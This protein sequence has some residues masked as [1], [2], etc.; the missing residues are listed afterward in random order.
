MLLLL[1]LFTDV[2]RYITV[3]IP[4]VSPASTWTVAK[5]IDIG[6]RTALQR[7]RCRQRV[8]VPVCS[9]QRLFQG[10]RMR[11]F[12]S[13]SSAG[14]EIP[15]LRAASSSLV[16]L[17]ISPCSHAVYKGHY[18]CLKGTGRT[19]ESGLKLQCNLL[20]VVVV[21]IRRRRRA[22]HTASAH[23]MK[24]SYLFCAVP[25][26]RHTACSGVVNSHYSYGNGSEDHRCSQRSIL[27]V[28]SFSLFI[29]LMHRLF[30]PRF[31]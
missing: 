11:Y 25:Y 16:R 21:C 30:V 27:C 8:G 12:N 29:H 14:S 24:T 18:L 3:V 4:T 6:C 22:E 17:L 19:G 26:R 9:L 31:G 15:R 5:R 28:T 23:K 13:P 1:C 20:G 10:C 7:I 2:A